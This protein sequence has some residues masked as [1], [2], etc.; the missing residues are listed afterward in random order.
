[1]IRA[2]AALQM[3][4][5]N[6]SASG[7]CAIAPTNEPPRNLNQC[8][9]RS[10]K[11]PK[12]CCYADIP[13]KHAILQGGFVGGGQ[14]FGNE[15]RLGQRTGESIGRKAIHEAPKAGCGNDLMIIGSVRTELVMLGKVSHCTKIV[16]K[17]V[18]GA[19]VGLTMRS[20]SDGAFSGSDLVGVFSAIMGCT[21]YK[22]SSDFCQECRSSMPEF[23]LYQLLAPGN[24]Y[25]Y[26]QVFT[27]RR[28]REQD[29]MIKK[30]AVIVPPPVIMTVITRSKQ[31]LE[32]IRSL[33]SR[34]SR[35]KGIGMI[36]KY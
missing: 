35:R 9:V 11:L 32:S 17:L 6:L 21:M 14:E 26:A 34:E 4:R 22:A 27:H 20:S 2:A 25:M 1:M 3:R 23:G 10:P 31:E 18:S 36:E 7:A 15:R 13:A 19:S 8:H 30:T 24:P 33:W 28:L 5:P 16:I 29:I 12:L